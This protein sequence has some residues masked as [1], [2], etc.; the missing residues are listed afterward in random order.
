MGKRFLVVGSGFSGA[1]LARQLV[2][3]LNCKVTVFEERSHIGGNCHTER[4][5]ETG[6]ME[7]VYGP[8]IFNT[9]NEMVWKYVNQFTE[10]RP[11]INRV[12]AHTDRGVFSMPINLLTI[13]QFFNKSFSPQ[14]ARQFISTLGSSKIECPANFEEQALKFLGEELYFN[15]FRGYTLKQWGTDPVNL[16]ASILTR[17]PI[18]FNYDDNYYATHFQGI[19]VNGYTDLISNILN[20]SDIE[21]HLNTKYLKGNGNGFD[22]VFYSG[23]IDGYYDYSMGRLGYRTIYFEKHVTNLPD[24]QGNPVINYCSEKIP[25]TRVHEHKH[26]TPWEQHDKS[27][28]LVEYSR[29]TTETDVPFYPKRLINDKELLYKYRNLAISDE[30]ISFIGRLGTYRYMDMHHVIAESISFSEKVIEASF[31]GTNIPVFPNEEVKG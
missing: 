8:H 1:V 12:K 7:H 14:E 19:P 25:Y 15:F 22:H 29:E 3:A 31:S 20:H 30:K 10:F 6:I 21:V 2:E 24:Y 4:N 28:Y 18:R 13:N 5:Q 11:Y 16:P 9:S 26:F 23:P 27:L 17:L